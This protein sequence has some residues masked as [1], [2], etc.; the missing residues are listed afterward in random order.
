MKPNKEIRKARERLR[1]LYQKYA[2]EFY[3]INKKIDTY[4][5]NLEIK[6]E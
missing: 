1:E 6:D 3:E 5:E 2:K 4:L